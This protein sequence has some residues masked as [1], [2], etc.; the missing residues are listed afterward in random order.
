M[1]I[2]LGAAI[3]TMAMMAALAPQALADNRRFAPSQRALAAAD[4]EPPPRGAPTVKRVTATPVTAVDEK[5]VYTK[6]WFW[7]LTAAVVGGTIA[8]GVATN[9]APQHLPHA[10]PAGTASCFGDGRSP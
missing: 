6:W 4:D 1:M 9:E 3:V 8:L 10:C 5:P 7:A 2:R